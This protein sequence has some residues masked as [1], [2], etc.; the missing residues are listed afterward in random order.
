MERPYEVDEENVWHEDRDCDSFEGFHGGDASF[1][2]VVEG[3]VEH[4]EGVCPDC[5]DAD[6]RESLFSS[7]TSRLKH[8]H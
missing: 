5:V 4:G 2:G 3:V 1:D 7:A 8:L 6:D